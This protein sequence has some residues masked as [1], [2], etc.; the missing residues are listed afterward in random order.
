MKKKQKVQL[1]LLIGI[2]LLTTIPIQSRKCHWR[3]T[4]H[5]NNKMQTISLDANQLIEGD[6][7]EITQVLSLKFLQD[8][9]SVCLTITNQE[10][11]IAYKAT[12]QTGSTPL[13][14]ISLKHLNIEKGIVSITDGKNTI[15]S[16]IELQ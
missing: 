12:I 8:I 5:T 6:L 15:Y 1:I 13:Y 10:G 3:D 2:T 16:F 9:G 11:E 7:D 4:W 14:V